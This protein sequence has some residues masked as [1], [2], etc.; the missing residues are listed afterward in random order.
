MPVRAPGL[1][2]DQV[3]QLVATPLEKILY[4][5]DEVEYVHSRCRAR[6]MIITVRFYVGQDREPQP[7]EAVR[8]LD[9]HQDQAPPGVTGGS[10]RSRSTTCRS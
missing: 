3:E 2:A 8:Q 6:T 10:S 5:I 7:G 9:E 1:S 4:Q